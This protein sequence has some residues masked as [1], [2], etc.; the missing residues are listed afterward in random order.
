LFLGE[1][2]FDTTQGIPYFQLILGKLPPAQ[3]VRQLYIT[4]A[5]SVTGIASANM[6][7]SSFDKRVLAGQIQATSNDG[8]T[9]TVTT[10][11]LQGTKPWYVIAASPQALGSPSG[12]P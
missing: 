2:W 6:F 12:G 11:N 8:T 4:A 3:I 1:L 5:E 9:I 10:N 7:F